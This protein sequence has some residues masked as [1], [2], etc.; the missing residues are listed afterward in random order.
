MSDELPM[1]IEPCT[2]APSAPPPPTIPDSSHQRSALE[3]WVSGTLANRAVI[4]PLPDTDQFTGKVKGIPSIAALGLTE[5]EVMDALRDQLVTYGETKLAQGH[6][7]PIWDTTAP[8]V[9]ADAWSLVRVSTLRKLLKQR[10][11]MW[12]A[13]RQQ[14]PVH[15]V[16]RCL[17]EL[18]AV[19]TR[20]A[21]QMQGVSPPP[22]K[23]SP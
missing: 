6:A 16:E 23:S 8:E 14:L 4:A 15:C 7:L 18:D 12:G 13:E 2:P 9:S 3:A 1:V 19:V 21:M 5:G 20:H 10:A 11:A 22:A 17:V